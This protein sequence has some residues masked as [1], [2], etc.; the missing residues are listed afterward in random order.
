MME[1][2]LFSDAS[3][4]QFLNEERI[5]GSRCKKCQ[6]LYLPPRPICIKCYGDEME[7]VEMKGKGK[8][9][10]FTCIGIGPAFMAEEGFDRK[11]P[12]CSGV[13]ELDER[14]RIDARIEG[15]D[16]NNP[17]T[18]GIGTP[19]TAEFLHRGEGENMR[20]FPAFRPI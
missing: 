10:A 2:R 20:T 15:F 6:A 18:I 5:M 17:E 1:E 16:N 3:Y 11:N 9:V 12:Y 14:V 7:W 13:V 8:L 19:V 4:E